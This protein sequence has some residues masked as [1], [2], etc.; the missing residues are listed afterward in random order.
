M[1]IVLQSVV[2]GGLVWVVWQVWRTFLRC[3]FESS[4]VDHLHGPV[5]KSTF[6]G[7]WG[8][9]TGHD[10]WAFWDDLAENYGGVVKVQGLLGEKNLHVSDPAALHTILVKEQS[11]FPEPYMFLTMNQVVLGHGLFATE[12]AVHRKQR[13][14]L[15]PA[16][17]SAYLKRLTPVFAQVATRLCDGISAQVKNGAREVDMVKWV[18]RAAL[19]FIGQGGM[20]YSF[21]SLVSNEPNAHRDAVKALLPA[22]FDIPHYLVVLPLARFLVP[23][24]YQRWLVDRYPDKGVQRLKSIVDLLWD[25][26]SDIITARRVAVE[27]SGEEDTAKDIISILLRAN[28]KASAEDRLPDDQLVAQVSTMISA[29]TDTSS[30]LMARILSLLTQHPEVQDKLRKEV[31]E[32]SVVEEDDM[33]YDTVLSLPYLDAIYRETARLYPVSLYIQRTAEKDT[34]LPLWKPVM[35]KHG[36]SIDSLPIAKGT[37]V[38]IGI[39][40]YNRSK[41]IWGD[42]AE[43]WKP[44]RWLAPLP[45]TFKSL[46]GTAV[47][48]NMM[49][50]IGGPR[51]CIGFKYAELEIKTILCHLLKRFKFTATDQVVMWNTSM[52]VY[53]TTAEKTSEAK[54]MMNVELVRS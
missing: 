38:M 2:A 46:P 36:K 47:Y 50:F 30:N 32:S 51:G 35:D 44:E 16:F 1:G 8:D 3:Y 42:D 54:M 26:S 14:I 23:H 22:V 9:V 10:S 12:G 24:R 7:S 21:D 49:T 43:E 52:V 33:S 34:V 27:K 31:L 5:P 25:K 48:S 15:N 18:A 29:A 17:A 53:P 39:Y 45:D 13:K 20:G 19:E 41:A 40:A 28:M 4:S 6:L 11:N 37:P